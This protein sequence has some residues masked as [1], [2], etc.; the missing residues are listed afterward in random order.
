MSSST[1]VPNIESNDNHE[2]VF[3]FCVSSDDEDDDE[4]VL[5]D[6]ISDDEVKEKNMYLNLNIP[7]ASMGIIFLANK[8]EDLRKGERALMERN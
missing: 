2:E 8:M 3:I 1:E 7:I 4:M 6:G 5:E